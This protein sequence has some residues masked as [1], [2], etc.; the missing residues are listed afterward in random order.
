MKV[1]FGNFRFD[2]DYRAGSPGCRYTPNGDGWPPEA[3][4]IEVLSGER[5]M[6]IVGGR[7]IWKLLA[8]PRLDRL[9]ERY[10][11]EILKATEEVLREQ[12]EEVYAD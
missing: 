12:E 3:P 8:K 7:S 1:S 11:D 10:C 5:L 6:R 4:E 2:V 9:V